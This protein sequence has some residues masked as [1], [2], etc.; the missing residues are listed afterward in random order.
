M[1]PAV[2]KVASSDSKTLSEACLLQRKF[3]AC[4]VRCSPSLHAEGQSFDQLIRA[5]AAVA[6]CS[7]HVLM[8]GSGWSDAAMSGAACRQSSFLSL[9]LPHSQTNCVRCIQIS[10]DTC[11]A[12]IT[13]SVFVSHV[14]YS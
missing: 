7:T 5:V 6:H 14:V 10:A 9:Q 11:T 13:D 3:L 4:T 1:K 12:G 8:S 2:Y